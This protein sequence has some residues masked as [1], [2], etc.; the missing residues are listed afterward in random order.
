ME[1]LSDA[2]LPLPRQQF[3]IMEKSDLKTEDELESKEHS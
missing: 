1:T 3:L 2:P